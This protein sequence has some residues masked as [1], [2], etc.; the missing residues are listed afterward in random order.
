MEL[1]HERLLDS[2]KTIGTANGYLMDPRWVT[3]RWKYPDEY[4]RHQYPVIVLVLDREAGRHETN[5]QTVNE[6]FFHVWVFVR[7][8]THDL[9]SANHQVLAAVA[10]IKTAV[11]A[12]LTVGDDENGNPLAFNVTVEGVE[13]DAGLFE[14]LGF[15]RVTLKVEYENERLLP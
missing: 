5:L 10:D 15:G 1:I 7:V 3:D 6:L 4:E 14:P 9:T 8:E 13:T 11:L 12:D 2:L